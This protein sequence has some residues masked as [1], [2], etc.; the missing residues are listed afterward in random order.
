MFRNFLGI[1]SDPRKKYQVQVV[2]LCQINIFC[3]QLTQNSTTDFVRF[4]KI[5]T[6]SSEIQNSDKDNLHRFLEI[7]ENFEFT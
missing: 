1:N 2:V 7:V 3:H 4:T 6:N 5:Y